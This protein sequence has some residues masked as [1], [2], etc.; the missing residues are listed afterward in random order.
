LITSS[1]IKKLELKLK[2]MKKYLIL[3]VLAG[4]FSCGE[5]AGSGHDHAKM[6][7]ESTPTTTSKSPAKTAMANIGETHVHI[8]YNAP[9]VRER[10]IWGGLVANG[11]VWVAG[12]HMATSIQF[13]GPV[14]IAGK[15]IP[16]G[17]YGFFVIPEENAWTLI[18]NSNW[19]QHLT[20][21]YSE[22]EDIH[23]WQVTPEQ[24]EFSEQLAY[25][26]NGADSTVSLAW[27]N[28]LV[29]FKVTPLAP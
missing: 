12:A 29:K 9:S 28:K 16:E 23:R 2:T 18:L 8:Q 15:Q 25:A 21:E 10:V 4:L 7:A 14:E 17:K 27:E 20:D 19:D 22:Q 13:Y 24:G 1:R 3:A 5:K 6:T 26:V 11:Q